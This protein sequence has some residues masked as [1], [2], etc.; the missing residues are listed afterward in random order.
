MNV[1]PVSV[2][3]LNAGLLTVI[4][5]TVAVLSATV[6][7]VKTFEIT[8]GTTPIRLAVAAVPMPALL[9][10]TWLVELRCEP[11]VVV[12]TPGTLMVQ[13]PPAGTVNPDTEKAV[14]E[15]EEVTP[16]NPPA[17]QVPVIV[18]A[19][20]VMLVAPGN[21]S[22]KLAPVTADPFEFEIV[23]LIVDSPPTGIVE[24]VKVLA[25]VGTARPLRLRVP[26]PTEA[27]ALAQLALAVLM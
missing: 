11:T 2:D 12:V 6:E 20:N 13:L 5:S 27:G 16:L 21:V 4:D 15:G 7:G 17:V 25:R 26:E 22:E 9:V 14:T 18:V 8:G 3:P 10:V 24:G 19:A 1:T 23:K